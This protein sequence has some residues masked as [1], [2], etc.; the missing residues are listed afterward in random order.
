MRTT[1]LWNDLQSTVVRIGWVNGDGCGERRIARQAF[2]RPRGALLVRIPT[3]AFRLR[4]VITSFAAT[5]RLV[6]LVSELLADQV[7]LL[8]GRLNIKWGDD[9]KAKRGG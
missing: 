9:A 2:F 5:A 1:V 4:V 8:K 3:A 7:Y 6:N